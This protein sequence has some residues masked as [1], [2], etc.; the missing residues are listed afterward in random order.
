[1]K[2]K[3][4]I[5][6]FSA[7]YSPY[8]SGAELFVK[9]V[10]ERLADKY[11][12]CVITSRLSSKLSSLEIREKYIIKRVGLGFAGDKFLFIFLA[13]LAALKY[14]PR[15]VHAVMESYAGVAL[16]FFRFLNKK[17]PTVLTLQSGD[18]DDPK[19]QRRIP[20]WLWQR[21]HLTPDRITAISSFLAQRAEKLGFPKEKIS[22]VPNGVDL[23][24]VPQN[25]S[26]I[27]FRII[28]LARLSWEKGINYLIEAMPQ[29]KKEF[30][31]AHL[32]LV[33]DG[34]ER[35]RLTEQ[36]KKL[37]LEKSVEFRGK[38]SHQKALRELAQSAV[39]VCP[40]L[41]EGLGIAFLEAMATRVPI[42]GTP[43]GGIPDFLRDRETGLF[44]QVK[45]PSSIAEK[46]KELLE[47][48]QLRE[49]LMET[50][51]KLVEKKYSWDKIVQQI[52]EIYSQIIT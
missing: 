29:V 10:V 49:K 19:K 23:K 38:L 30:T 16:W 47:N 15:I 6:V 5:V 27:P 17:I 20:S 37:N 9:E 46:I 36:V 1:M 35:K 24:S 44:C 12:F 43:I 42:I 25:I 40:S 22:I 11:D 33:G 39:F 51:Y 3:P 21:I 52:D 18:L 31:Q 4:K 34:P 7:F 41:A 13:P 45:N 28:C 8:M 2:N 50:A 26:Q 14:K 32:V 48:H